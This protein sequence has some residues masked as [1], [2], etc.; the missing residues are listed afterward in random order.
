MVSK[1]IDERKGEQIVVTYMDLE[2][3][4][5]IKQRKMWAHTFNW[6]GLMNTQP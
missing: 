3:G 4:K 2:S 6:V 1:E 5:V